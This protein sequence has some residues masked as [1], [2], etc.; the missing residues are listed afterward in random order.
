[1]K[2]NLSD[3]FFCIHECNMSPRRGSYMG[4]AQLSDEI[5]NLLLSYT[6]TQNKS[7]KK[8]NAFAL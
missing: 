6:C 4:S 2:P 5:S 7:T 8:K 3:T 1:M